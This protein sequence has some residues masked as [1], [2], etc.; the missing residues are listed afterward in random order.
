MKEITRGFLAGAIMSG[1]VLFFVGMLVSAW[2][3]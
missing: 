2:F 3:F 1:T